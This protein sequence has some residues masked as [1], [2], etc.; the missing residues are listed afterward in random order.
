MLLIVSDNLRPP[1]AANRVIGE[2]TKPMPA[3]RAAGENGCSTGL[4]CA[5]RRARARPI[6]IPAWLQPPRPSEQRSVYGCSRRTPRNGETIRWRG[7]VSPVAAPQCEVGHTSEE[8][9]T[10]DGLRARRPIAH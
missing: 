5:T 4:A 10:P 3:N 2:A 6:G 7:G 1:A 8:I 9:L